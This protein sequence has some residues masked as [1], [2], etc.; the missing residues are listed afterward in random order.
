VT[1]DQSPV[2]RLLH[3]GQ[4]PDRLERTVGPPIQKGSTVLL[5]DA[6]SLYDDSRPTYGRQGLA[7]HDALTAALAE[8]E[9]AAAVRLFPSGLAS[10]TGALLAMLKAGDEVLVA[11]SIYKPTRRFCDRV[12]RRYGVGVRYYAPPA[13]RPSWRGFAAARPG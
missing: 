2:S 13:R 10:M 1:D 9:H 6:A 7:T 3:A 11:D 12:L 4:A 8:L 5:P